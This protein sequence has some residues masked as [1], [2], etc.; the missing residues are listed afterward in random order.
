MEVRRGNSLTDVVHETGLI[1]Y[2]LVFGSG[3]LTHGLTNAGR[4][5]MRHLRV[6][7]IIG[8]TCELRALMRRVQYPTRQKQNY[9]SLSW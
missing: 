5:R 1:Y 7:A 6:I 2:H 8:Y 4:E 3:R 9:L